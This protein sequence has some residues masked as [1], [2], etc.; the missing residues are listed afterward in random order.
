MPKITVK[1]GITFEAAEGNRL[2]VALRE[3]DVDILHRCGGY[4]GCTTCRVKV[5]EGEPTRMTE[6]ELKKLREQDK[7]GE[8]RLSCQ[9]ECTH[10]MTVEPLMSIAST[11]LADRGPVPKDY[12]TPEPPVW[13]EKPAD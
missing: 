4:A 2:L 11:G 8:F 3:H 12:I 5:Y 9:I 10:D 13:T 1:D 6:A 7:L